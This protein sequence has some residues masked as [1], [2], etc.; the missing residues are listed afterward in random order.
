MKMKSEFKQIPDMVVTSIKND[1]GRFRRAVKLKG[2]LV[3]HSNIL[4]RRTTVPDGFVSDGASVPQFFWSRYPPFGEYLEA[5]VVHDLYCV[6]GHQGQSPISSKVAA[7]VFREA[8]AAIG[9]S[10]WKRNVMYLAV[11]WFGPRFKRN[12]S[13][14]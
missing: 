4:G 7:Q 1:K 6:L 5:A 11:L 2:D 14:P 3:Y 8:M 10:K 12:E 13:K 9:Y